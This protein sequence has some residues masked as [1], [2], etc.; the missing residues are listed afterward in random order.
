MRRGQSHKKR[1]LVSRLLVSFFRRL[2]CHRNIIII[3]EHKTEHVPVSTSFQILAITA[4][5]GFVIWGSYSTGN[6]MAAQEALQEKERKIASASLE[7]RRIE[8]EFA[9]LKRDLIKMID[10]EDT[11]EPSEY[12]KFVIEQYKNGGQNDEPV[13]IDVSQ[14]GSVQHS[15]VF[16]RIAFLEQTV[17]ALKESH[18]VMIESIRA[19][20]R[21]KLTELESIIK[22][23]G[24][25]TAMLE[26]KA[27]ELPEVADAD[28][29]EVKNSDEP[30][31]G[32]YDPL[33]EDALLER[34]EGLY[35]DLKRMTLL[36]D[37]VNTL[38][39]S[40]PME[41]YRVTSGFGVRMDP[42]RK[43]LAR[44]TGM[45]FSGPHHSKVRATTDG[46]VKE[47]G[48]RGAYGLSVE[49]EHPFGVTTLYGHLYRI[50]VEEGQEVRKGDVIGIQGST[51]RSTGPHLHYEVRYNG[52]RLNPAQFLK[53]GEKAAGIEDVRKIE[54]E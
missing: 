30:R 23:T 35:R 41:Q 17:E 34:D 39:L 54:N 22:T 14:L 21:G 27:G 1:T 18:E 47:T 50:N 24:L 7:N 3:S 45:D 26:R 10:E 51:G 38:P 33:Y 49:V 29:E 52:A 19:T 15:A 53:A 42:F 8:S 37:V 4:L 5:L 46:I 12:A 11:K 16:E 36:S 9:L 40:V 32:P 31:G 44:H 2:F 13:D 28:L 43:R 25:N 20:A 48:R 6:Y